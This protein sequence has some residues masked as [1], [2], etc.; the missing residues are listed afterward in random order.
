MSG[1]LD[2][3]EFIASSNHRVGVLD[4]LDS[5]ACDRDE[6]RAVTGA[7]SPTIGRILADFQDRNWI[8]R[9][10]RTYQLTSLGEYVADQFA[11]FREAMTYERRL[12]E[13]WPWLPHDIDD[14]GV[15]LFT[16][17]VVSKPGPGF[18][19]KPVER[20]TELMRTTRTMRGF[21]VALLKS[22]NLEPFFDRTLN[23]MECEYI[24]PPAVFEDLLAWNQETV[25]EAATRP[26]YSVL[27]HNDLPLDKRCGVCLFDERVSICCYDPGT[28]T[29]QSL[30][31]TESDEM[32]TWAETHYER[33][34]TEARPL[35]DEDDLLSIG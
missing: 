33:F 5:C 19:Y 29:F 12:R 13:V 21:G 14:F 34:R 17:V 25:V 23:G 6:L 28:G 15:E 35:H 10:G 22:G 7:S 27:L 32:R 24:Y 3:I 2:D 18:P 11:Q 16:D 31:D 8:K 9:E 1:T 4:T 30:I 20:L 26:N